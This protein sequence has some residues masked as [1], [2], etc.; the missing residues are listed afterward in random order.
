[1]FTGFGGK[2]FFA[3]HLRF[4]LFSA[5]ILRHT[6]AERAPVI[7]NGNSIAAG[8]SG[9][10][11]NYPLRGDE[12]EMAEVV[13]MSAYDGMDL[14]FALQAMEAQAVG[15]RSEKPL[16]HAQIRVNPFEVLTPEQFKETVDA[17]ERNMGFEG[18]DRVVVAHK[19]NPC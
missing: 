15:T 16:Y 13:E 2:F 18:L 17:L 7:C 8:D 12:N 3:F 6:E 14:E 11:A 5:D 19:R 9:Q 1:L 10:L 4:S